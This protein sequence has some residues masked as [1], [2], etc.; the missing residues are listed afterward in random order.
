V[1]HG[2][3]AAG[4][5]ALALTVMTPAAFGHAERPSYYPNFDPIAKKYDPAPEI[6]PAGS[7][8]KYRGR[9]TAIVVCKADSGQRIRALPRKT[10]RERAVRKRNLSL[11]RHCRFRHIQQAVTA[12]RNGTRILV[13]PGV[14]KEEPS[15]AEPNPDPKC[16]GMYDTSEEH[17]TAPSYLYHFTCPNS[18]NMI[19]ITGDSPSDPDRKCDRKCNIQISGT[20]RPQDV[21]ITGE[22]SKLNVI[23]ADRADG[24]YLSNFTIEFSDFNNIYVLETNGF[25]LNKIVSRYSREYG[26][27]SFASDHGLY[28]NIEA[29]NSGDS[30]IYP[31]SG[32]E[33]HCARYGIEIRNSDSHDNTLGYSGT[34]GNGVWAHDNKFHDNSTGIVTDSFAA[35]H[36]GMP[37]DCA[38][39]EN[40]EVYSN[41]K[42]LFNAERDE[43]CK[44]PVEQ[45]DPKIVCPT[46]QTA[47]GTGMMIAGGNGDITR[48]NYIYDNWRAGAR[49]FWVP[50]SLRGGDSTGQ[51]SNHDTEQFDT[52]NKNR[53]D[54]NKVGVR[55]DGTRDP[56]GVD[57]WWDE[58]GQGNCWQG[59]TG[60]G[61]AKPT[62]DPATL[63]TCSS[64]GSA[65]SSGNPAK[66][67]FQVPCA[68]WN[69]TDNTDP[70]GCDWFDRPP[71]PK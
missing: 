23:R 6:G 22:R 65:F 57:F 25:H 52:S 15:R 45:R 42:D 63:P 46:F 17:G 18:Q 13:L 60:P 40:N 4:A 50:T 39:W 69:P 36:P 31:G 7:V 10:R 8:P 67:T 21:L 16:N 11:L 51:S 28:E 66:Q 61:G 70:P 48:G 19:A 14:Y 54:D 5:C 62:S 38:K 12:A 41:N 55:P 47:V 30:G 29:F 59:N 34:A 71:E 3:A 32:P 53:Y 49:L 33:G 26:I 24:V 9:G 1:R 43:Y 37:Q 58:E 44:K 64:G 27:L 68:T 20:A 56:N 35:G 2:I